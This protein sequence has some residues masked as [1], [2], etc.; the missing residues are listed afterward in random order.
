M[1]TPTFSIVIPTRDRAV[2]FRHTL[3]TVA[4]QAGDDYEIVVADNASGPGIRFAV[5]ELAP[6]KTRY[7]RSETILSMTGNW[8][9]GLA[10]CRGEYVTVLGDDD[11]FLPSSLALA[12][13]LIAATKAKIISWQWHTYW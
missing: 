12:R 1:T 5:E 13:K 11:A 3:A 7:V 4:W 6:G 2:T 9:N 10:A 8:E